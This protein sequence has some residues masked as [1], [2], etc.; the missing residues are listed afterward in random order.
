MVLDSEAALTGA[1]QKLFDLRNVTVITFLS[2]SP[3]LM[4][5]TESEKLRSD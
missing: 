3:P 5:F 2:N 4:S 1:I